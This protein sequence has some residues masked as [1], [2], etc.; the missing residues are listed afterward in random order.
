MNN[1]PKDVTYKLISKSKAT[2]NGKITGAQVVQIVNE[3]NTVR[4][5][6]LHCALNHSGDSLVYSTK[7][8]KF[9]I[10]VGNIVGW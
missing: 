8:E 6:T 10:D 3:D 2:S 4:S 5:R 7:S 9:A 1:G